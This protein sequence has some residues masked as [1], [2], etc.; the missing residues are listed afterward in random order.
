MASGITKKQSLN[1]KNAII[2]IRDGKILL[3][4]EDNP[5]PYDLAELMQEFNG[6]VVN[7]SVGVSVDVE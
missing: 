5:A 6:A 4:I 2:D 1:V 3:E 7:I